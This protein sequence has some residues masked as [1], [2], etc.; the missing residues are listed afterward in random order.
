MDTPQ[1]TQ[2][3]TLTITGTAESLAGVLA[4]ELGELELT[5]VLF[6]DGVLSFETSV[7]FQGQVLDLDFEGTVTGDTIEGGFDTPFGPIPAT[8]ARRAP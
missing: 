6:T 5:D 7:E 3:P 4:G 1:G 2:R 8:G